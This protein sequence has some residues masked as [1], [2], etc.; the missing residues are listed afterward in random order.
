MWTT[1]GSPRACPISMFATGVLSILLIALILGCANDTGESSTR[2]ALTVAPLAA[3]DHLQALGVAQATQGNWA[4]DTWKFTS[5]DTRK[6]F[7]P[8]PFPLLC[9]T[10]AC[11]RVCHSLCITPRALGHAPVP[12][13]SD[14]NG[15]L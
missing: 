1:S 11:L 14:P 2:H 13:V 9:S 15:R 7:I 3:D 4:D 5:G 6:L 8:R 10:M 12:L